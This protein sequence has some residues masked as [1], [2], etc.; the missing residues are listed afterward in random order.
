IG[1][2]SVEHCTICL[3]PPENVIFTV[4]DRHPF[5]G[6][7]KCHRSLCLVCLLSKNAP[8]FSVFF[9]IGAHKC[10]TWIPF[11]Q[12]PSLV[13]FRYSVRS[14]E[15]GHINTSGHDEMGYAHFT[16]CL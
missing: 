3:R 2:Y 6:Q 13:A 12:K 8:H 7:E 9:N 14:P 15:I 4:K 11:I 10:Y 5:E 16:C 1:L